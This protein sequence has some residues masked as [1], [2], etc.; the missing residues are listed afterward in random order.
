MNADAPFYSAN[1]SLQGN[2]STP[3]YCFSYSFPRE[4]LKEDA[5]DV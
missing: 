1:A 5:K 3:G 4:I 2:P